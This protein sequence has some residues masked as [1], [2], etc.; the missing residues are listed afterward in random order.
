MH[1]L[2]DAAIE[3]KGSCHQNVVVAPWF[4][5][6]FKSIIDVSKRW[7]NK[8]IWKEIEPAFVNSTNFTHTIAKL[9]IAEYLSSKGHAVDII[10][11]G[12][13]ASPDLKMQA[14]GGT[15]EWINIEC[16]QPY[17]L[18]GG[19][20]VTTDDLENIVKKSMKK[21]KRQL[22]FKTPG[23]L[24]IYGFNQNMESIA[25]LKKMVKSRLQDTERPNLCGLLIVMFLVNFKKI[26]ETIS[27][28]P[29]ISLNF[30]PNPSY[31]GIVDI[32]GDEPEVDSGSIGKKEPLQGIAKPAVNSR[33]LLYSENISPMIEG[34]GNVSFVCAS[35]G[36]VI[37]KNI[38]KLSLLNIVTKCPSC[39]NYNEFV[40]KENV[41]INVKSIAFQRGEYPL[42][43]KLRIKRNICLIGL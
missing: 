23:I 35:C 31:F 36:F 26:Q 3:T 28:T 9:H 43:S 15:Q 42:K 33:V 8:P 38:W 4:L 10:P 1:V 7:Q 40:S 32:E 12:T 13:E 19:Q 16:Y 20:K 21:A 25:E 18:N 22:G 17:I 6:E 11:R 34:K 37:A 2:L 39:Q 24:A 29:S 5:A 14:I 41:E 30:S 27:F